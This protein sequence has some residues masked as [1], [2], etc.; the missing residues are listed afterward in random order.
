M[1]LI[2]QF[3]YSAVLLNSMV[4]SNSLYMDFFFLS[5]VRSLFI[6]H[7]QKIPENNK[8]NWRLWTTLSL[9]EMEFWFYINFAID[10]LGKYLVSS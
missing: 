8:H 1:P 3:F 5:I 9:L 4:S 7:G 2:T 6:F 10:I